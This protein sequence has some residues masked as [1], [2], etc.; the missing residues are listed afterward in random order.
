MA[1]SLLS[2]PR[3]FAVSIS[4]GAAI[5]AGA[6]AFAFAILF[7]RPM[8]LLAQDWWSNPEAGHGL[9]LA[10][11][12]AW[13]AWRSGIRPDATGN[14]VTGTL[15]LVGAVLLRYLSGLAAELFTM[16]M[17]MVMGMAGIIIYFFGLRQV[18]RWWLPLSLF[19][20]SVPLPEILLG[21]IAM[22]LQFK[23]SQIGTAL[24]EWRG[25]PVMMNGNVIRIPGH[26]LFVAEAC[27]GLRSLTAL[28]SLALLTGGL[29]LRYPMSRAV[30]VLLAVPVAVIINGVRVFL[31]AF[32]V[33]FVSPE[34]GQGFM[35]LTEGWLMFVVA[36]SILAG[37]A[38]AL[39][40]GERIFGDLRKVKTTDA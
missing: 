30:L 8:A 12:A 20:L 26:E 23:A 2:V 35:H 38:W 36:L 24:L 22:P 34:L 31:T 25:V 39:S 40:A 17:S 29:M 32:L 6:T 7:A 14:A 9:L 4:R 3:A 19:T 18:L 15:L 11:L 33:F 37:M 21:R 10:P 13:L 16:R 28:L 5:T 27:S 1:T